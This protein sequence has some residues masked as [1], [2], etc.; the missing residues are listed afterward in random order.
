M[1]CLPRSRPS[2]PQKRILPP[3]PRS[4]GSATPLEAT[5][6]IL[7]VRTD[8]EGRFTYANR[9]YLEY[10]G[11][12]RLPLGDFA[13]DQVEPAD[14]PRVAEV[15]QQALARPGE[16][17]WVEFGKPRPGVAWSRSRWEFVAVCD[18]A[19]RPVE[20]QCSGYDISD[21]Y[22]QDCFRQEMTDLLAATLT[23]G[24]GNPPVAL[25]RR[26]LEAAL[27]IVPAA[28]AGSVTLRGPDGRFHFVAAEGYDLEA[29][30]QVSL[31]PAE[32]LSLSRHIQARIFG[33][34]DLARFNA[35]IDPQRRAVLEGVGKAGRIQAMLSVPVVV[36]GEVR[37]YLYLDHFG[38]ADAFDA[39][40][41]RHAEV[42]AYH[43]A[44]VLEKEDLHQRAEHLRRHDPQTGLA[45]LALLL[46]TLLAPRSAGG[47]ALLA[48][49]LPDLERL[50]ELY[51]PQWRV[52]VVQTVGRRILEGVRLGDL[53]AWDGRRF[54][55]LLDGVDE[56]R[57]ALPV[58]ER[59]R[60][61]LA[62]PIPNLAGPTTPPA[63]G[64][65][66]ASPQ[67]PPEELLQ[68]AEVALSQAAPGQAVFFEAS[69]QQALLE[70]QWLVEA[71]YR[72]IS[73]RRP[74]AE[75]G[76]LRLYFQP[77]LELAGGRPVHLEAL[78]RW[79]HPHRGLIPP[80]RFIP[81]AERQGW[82]AELG[83]WT[84]AQAAQASA[85]WGIPVAVNL[86]ALQL[87]PGL[88]EAVAAHC[89]E[90]GI[91]PQRLILEV[92]EGL[93]LEPA[94][95]GVLQ[96]LAERGHPLHL[97]DFG[98]GY[99]SLEQL[100]RLP[101]QAVKL[102]QGF[103][104]DLGEDPLPNS[105]TARVLAAVRSLGEGLGLEVIVEGIE[106]E[107]QHRYLLAQGFRLGQGYWLGRPQSARKTARRLEA[108]I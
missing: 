51:G 25:L 56:P 24:A 48:L 61:S 91:G 7:V 62:Q 28:Q 94:A 81:L 67:T 71:L 37:A 17:F 83:D 84:I 98:S 69:L 36:R 12:E 79:R 9:A 6:H 73:R 99:S 38:R 43:L 68:Q 1:E 11:L 85:A 60:Q 47:R 41:L 50:E 5:R 100:T 15:V 40:D 20:L 54:W 80:G 19:G 96:A 39:L 82:M 10:M 106:T 42:L 74:L 108:P 90:A 75:R 64:I 26:V 102:G 45:N 70:E 59:L 13:L 23:T 105:P 35:R 3:S 65:A 44:L 103:L 93:A 63:V 66:L 34:E 21:E 86:S 22:R 49:R 16:A 57:E 76:E 78:L 97:D 92:T 30:S 18:P 89:R 101:I 53:L 46:E 32:P 4:E 8:L 95:M 58:V 87:G 31:D 72:A 104:R 33:A 52:T 27:R 14:R 2:L 29:L 107:T 55:L 88:P 77:V